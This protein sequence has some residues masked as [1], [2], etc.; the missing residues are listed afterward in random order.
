MSNIDMM[1]MFS[2]IPST[3]NYNVQNVKNNTNKSSDFESTLNS[4]SNLKVSCKKKEDSIPKYNNNNDNKNKYEC[5]CENTC[6]DKYEDKQKELLGLVQFLNLIPIDNDITVG[7]KEFNNISL[8]E[9]VEMPLNLFLSKYLDEIKDESKE[10]NIIDLEKIGFVTDENEI[11]TFDLNKHIEFMNNILEDVN[12]EC[13][14]EKPIDIDFLLDL[15]NQVSKQYDNNENKVSKD[16]LNIDSFSLEDTLSSIKLKY[17]ESKQSSDENGFVEISDNLTENSDTYLKFSQDL[18]EQSNGNSNLKDRDVDILKEIASKNQANNSPALLNQKL[19]SFETIVNKT[20]SD[21]VETPSIR[22]GFFKED[23]INTVEYMD[24]NNVQKLSVKLTPKELGEMSIEFIKDGNI[25]K[26]VLTLS[27]D[28]TLTMVE[29]G[30][31]DIKEHIKGL[32]QDNVS[33]EIK[34]SSQTYNLFSDTMNQNLNKE[35]F[36]NNQKPKSFSDSNRDK[37]I[38]DV[39]ELDTVTE[40]KNVRLGNVNLFA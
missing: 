37:E 25:S 19:T 9:E 28:E 4:N 13:Q 34:S 17:L 24:N 27:K 11:T 2:N 29:K 40:N 23:L 32:T 33:I 5:K 18:S 7:F 14:T 30:L 38:E 39:D 22:Q 6:E 12:N 8:D 3:N 26:L 10:L 31:I 21:T 20:I 16:L 35:N 36:F 15:K 1:S